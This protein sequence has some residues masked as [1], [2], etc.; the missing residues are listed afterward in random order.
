VICEIRRSGCICGTFGSAPTGRYP[1]VPLRFTWGYSWCHLSEALPQVPLRF[2]WG[3]SWCRLF[4]ALPQVPLRFTW[5][6]S[7]CH[8][9]EV[10]SGGCLAPGSAS[11]HLGLLMVPPLRGCFGGMPSPRFRFASPGVTHGAT[12]P[13]LSRGMP[14]PRFRFASP[15]VTHGATSPRLPSGGCLSPGSASLHLGLLMVSPL[16]GFFCLALGFVLCLAFGFVLGFCG[17]LMGG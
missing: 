5:G 9:S 15:G 16:R 7:W 8:L 3:C 14:S 2:S 13:R 17:G 11:L 1:Q 4:E 10:V 6:Y 12:S